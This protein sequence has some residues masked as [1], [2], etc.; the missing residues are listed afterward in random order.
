[1]SYKVIKP[2][3][4]VCPLCGSTAYIEESD[5]LREVRYGI[6]CIGKDC[7]NNVVSRYSRS[8]EKAVRAFLES[9][10]TE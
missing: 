8:K 1:M 5:D 4:A 10:K 6:W 7:K 3:N 9:A 2:Y